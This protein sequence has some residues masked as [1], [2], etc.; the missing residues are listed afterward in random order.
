M[1]TNIAKIKINLIDTKYNT[2]G[3]SEGLSWL[4]VVHFDSPYIKFARTEC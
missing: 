4:L 2:E 3:H 1:M